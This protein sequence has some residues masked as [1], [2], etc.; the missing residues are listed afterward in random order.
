MT[1][2]RQV[3]R[4]EPRAGDRR[5]RATLGAA[6]SAA[7][8]EY[9]LRDGVDLEAIGAALPTRFELSVA[10]GWSSQRT[11]YD[12]FDGRLHARGLTLIHT[13]RRLALISE[14]LEL[15][16]VELS[17]RPRSLFAADLPEGRL[18]EALVPIVSVRA[19]SEIARVR[20]H[21]LPARVLNADAK[22]VVRLFVEKPSSL[23]PRVRVAGVRGYDKALAARAATRSSASS[24]SRRA[25]AAC[26]TR[27]SRRAGRPA[28]RARRRSSTSRCTRE[29]RGRRAAATVLLRQPARGSI[30]REPAR[31][32]RRRRHRV[33]A[34][35]PR[36]R[37]PHPLGPAPAARASSRRSRSRASAHEF[38][39]LQQ[40]T[41]AQPRPR[42]VP[43]RARRRRLPEAPT[44]CASCCSSAA[45]A[46]AAAWSARCAPSARPRCSPT[47][48]RSSTELV[49]APPS[50]GPTPRVRSGDVAASGSRAVYT[51]HGQDRAGR[52]TTTSPPEALHDLR[53]T[54]KELRYL[55]EFFAGAVPADVVKPTGARRS[56]RCRTRSGAS[57]TARSRRN[58]A[59]AARRGRRARG[60][61]RRA[62][63]DGLL[64]DR[65]DARAGRRPR[66]V[67]RALRRVRRTPTAR[68]ASG[69]RSR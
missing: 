57:R 42:R 54:G 62:D 4:P 8:I 53:K 48:R 20:S 60:R 30:E 23:P 55:L 3:A 29:Q 17:R 18:R 64:V 22:I 1:R 41:G 10:A 21:V 6:M 34:R 13:D 69:R 37:A 65:L 11:F 36:R 43:A 47:G 58:A 45:A 46:S 63:G 9:M 39:W 52:S 26:P 50:T 56:R 5:A 15:A 44:R 61:P 2:P 31:H 28:R 7:G 38:R 67:R 40:V 68:G 16:T 25:G 32:A 14:Q 19:L 35:P 27:R 51:Q 33:P 49:A 59:L 66:R 12:T 24:G